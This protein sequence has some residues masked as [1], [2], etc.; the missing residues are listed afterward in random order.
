MSKTPMTAKASSSRK[1]ISEENYRE[2]VFLINRFLDMEGARQ[3][4][5]IWRKEVQ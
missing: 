1:S 4:I 2:S 5:E 3:K